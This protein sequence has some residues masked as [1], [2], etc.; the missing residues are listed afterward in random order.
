MSH[1]AEH[2]QFCINTLGPCH[3]FTIFFL[4]SRVPSN[5]HY[6]SHHLT[7]PLFPPLLHKQELPYKMM[8]GQSHGSILTVAVHSASNLQDVEV[9]IPANAPRVLPYLF[10]AH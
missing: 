9:T 7:K 3:Q 4:F 5:Y 1:F 2:T 8:L 6:H 10:F